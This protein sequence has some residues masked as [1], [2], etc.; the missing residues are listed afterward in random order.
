MADEP[1]DNDSEPILVVNKLTPHFLCP[2]CEQLYRHP[3]INIKCGH[4]F[5]KKCASGCVRCPVDNE[6]CDANQLIL[7]R[8]VV[9]QIDE[10][11]IYC[12]YGVR[13][14]NGTYVQDSTGCQ[15]QIS[16]GNRH[17]HE[18]EC[19]FAPKPCPNDALNCGTFRSSELQQHLQIC[20]YFECEHRDKG[21][22]FQGR[23]DEVRN[24]LGTCGYRGLPMSINHK[25]FENQ[26]K[27]LEAENRCL[28][29]KLDSLTK[30]VEV[31]E[32]NKNSLELSLDSC[33]SNFQNLNKKH[34][35][36]QTLVEQLMTTRNR[37]SVSSPGN[38]AEAIRQRT[39]STSSFS[40]PKLSPP[41]SMK[42]ETWK[43][44]FQFKC[45]GSLRGHKN[46]VWCFALYKERLFS[47]GGDSLVKVWDLDVLTNGCIKTMEGHT[48]VVHTMVIHE[49]SLV[50]AGDDLSIRVWNLD[51]YTEENCVFNAHDNLISSMVIVGDNLFTASY[52]L[53]KVWDMKTL[54]LVHTKSGLH[55]WVRALIVS[56]DKE[57][58]Y[59]GCH[60]TIG[61]WNTSGSFQ[62][63]GSIPHNYGS[64]Y[65]LAITH[66]FLIAGTY[67]RNIQVF[68]LS[69]NQHV[70]SLRG[71]IGVVNSLTVTPS[72]RFLISSS[73][74]QTI[75]I[76][77]LENML[78]I[79]TLHRHE[80]GVNAVIL[81]GDLLLSGSED[82][83][84]KLFQYFQMQMGF[85][86][87]T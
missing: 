79:Q 46:V 51:S 15:E 6:P 25:D 58:L 12:K 52:S 33:Q 68:N 7:N 38:S 61:I 39:S 50:T 80:G 75:M 30:R 1:Y 11:L 53:I 87:Q 63:K 72:G 35:A 18:D 49:N 44:P 9:G 16:I 84:I 2:V 57:C 29:E 73:S 3:V 62:L 26:T 41:A 78:P 60:N 47:S 81:Y 31:L 17:Q 28:R 10:L 74:D 22:E 66:E 48:G 20:P 85:A 19:N 45:I 54:S 37:R 76:W 13:Q 5:C 14:Q 43:M 42:L 56:Q 32:G 83:E 77:N 59:S 69:D 23:Q 4:T 36:L 70:Y 82:H 71:H 55:H 65:S 64:I 67:N 86:L 34:E 40:S 24:H 27:A 21:C 8:L